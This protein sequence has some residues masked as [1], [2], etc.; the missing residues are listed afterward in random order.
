MAQTF[1]AR[2][3]LL[4][5]QIENSKIFNINILKYLVE[6]KNKFLLCLLSRLIKYFPM[7]NKKF[8]N[9]VIKITKIINYLIF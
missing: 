7:N 8:S 1:E 9:S 6:N 4:L 5:H 3:Y 2:T